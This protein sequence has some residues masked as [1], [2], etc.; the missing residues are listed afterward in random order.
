MTL[1]GTSAAL[2]AASTACRTSAFVPSLSGAPA[3]A[4]FF[5]ASVAAESA[6]P[7][8]EMVAA[9]LAVPVIAAGMLP[10]VVPA[11]GE[12]LLSDGGVRSMVNCSVFCA[13]RPA[14]SVAF[15]TSVCVPSA[16]MIEPER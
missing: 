9:S 4:K 10:T 16:L 3:M 5:A 14:Q 2:P 11:A 1:Y 12:R 7:A 6:V 15:T 13:V 8:I